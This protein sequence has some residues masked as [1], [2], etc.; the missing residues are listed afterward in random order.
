MFD[1][2][3][4]AGFIALFVAVGGLGGVRARVRVC[5]GARV[6]EGVGRG[7]WWERG[8]PNFTAL[9]LGRGWSS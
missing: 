2:V 3:L 9:L 4:I 8:A 5:R 6:R 7:W 1:P